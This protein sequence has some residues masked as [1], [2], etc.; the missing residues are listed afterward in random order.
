[1]FGPPLHP[2]SLYDSTDEVPA[3]NS[4]GGSKFAAVWS[5]NKVQ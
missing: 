3:V 4:S 2:F 5:V 1:M